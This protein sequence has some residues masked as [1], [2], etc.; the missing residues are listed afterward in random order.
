MDFHAHLSTAEVIGFL[1]GTWCPVSRHLR[2]VR[3]LPAAQLVSLDSAVEVELDPAGMPA[4][5]EAL[6]AEDLSAVG[7]YHSHP[8]FPTQPSVRDIH[9]QAAYQRLFG[10]T[11]PFVGAIVG[12]WQAC[13]EATGASEM[14]WFHVTPE[15][16]AP[17]GARPRQF[18]V[19]A[20]GA[21]VDDSAANA[22]HEGAADAADAAVAPAAP[23]R[24]SLAAEAVVAA[25]RFGCTLL[26]TDFAA[27]WRE[28]RGSCR[29][30][31][32]LSLRSRV[33]AALREQGEALVASML[34]AVDDAWA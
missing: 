33:P 8:T 2:V 20:D 25:G 1:G 10:E 31:L 30:K 9:N 17:G 6:E 11:A 24:A 14:R 7:W 3:A 4:L 19:Q 34:Q 13:D 27:R 15:E 12:P 16:G 21:A 18:T 5:L 32:A 29:D 22:E 23:L 28:G 26:R